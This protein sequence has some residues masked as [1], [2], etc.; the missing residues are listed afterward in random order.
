MLVM[1]MPNLPPQ[2]APV[3]IAQANQAKPGNVKTTRTLGVCSPVPNRDFSLENVISPLGEAGMYLR[4]YV[5]RQVQNIGT[6]TILQQ[7]IHGILRLVTEADRGTLFSRGSSA[8]KPDAGLY[9]YLP[10]KGYLGKDQAIFLVEI[11][12]VTVK[13]VHFLQ[14]VDGPLGNTGAERRCSK[15][16]DMWKI[17][18]T[19]DA[20]GNS[21]S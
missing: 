21:T 9:A 19:V 7:P 1:E 10:E 8:L 3:M 14:A 2:N 17:S 15:T 4:N 13:V 11:G 18:S 12:G 6:A 16:G 5:H 20:N